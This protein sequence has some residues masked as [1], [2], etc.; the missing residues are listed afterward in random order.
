[1][2]WSITPSHPQKQPLFPAK[3]PLN[4]QTVQVPFLDNLPYILVFREPP[5]PPK[6]WIFQK[7][8]KTL[9]F[10]SLTSS[11]LL[12]VTKFLAKIFQFEF[13]VITEKKHFCL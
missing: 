6:S 1:M 3:S 7:T 9:K 12:K 5:S 2:H 8:P 10:S 4:L 11:Y 13:V